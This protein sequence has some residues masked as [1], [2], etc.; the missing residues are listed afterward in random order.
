MFALAL[1]GSQRRR[2]RPARG[3]RHMTALEQLEPRTLLSVQ[4]QL[5]YSLDTS[6]FMTPSRQALLAGALD[7]IAAKLDNTLAAEPSV[8]IN[9]W[10]SPSGPFNLTTSVPA[11]T[12][13]IYVFGAPLSGARRPGRQSEW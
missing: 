6:G 13:K 5:D 12:L 3:S 1:S 11:N 8:S 7:P 4:L 9:G 10:P 2:T